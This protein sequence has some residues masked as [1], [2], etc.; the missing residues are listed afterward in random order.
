MNTKEAYS[1]PEIEITH[2]EIEN[3]IASSFTIDEGDATG[4]ARSKRKDF[5]DTED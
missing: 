5:W 2:L 1:K 4:P 3:I